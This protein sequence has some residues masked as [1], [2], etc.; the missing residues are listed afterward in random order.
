MHSM[1]GHGRGNARGANG[2]VTVEITSVN[3]RTLEI[4]VH[5]PDALA[6][7]EPFLHEQVRAAVQRGRVSIDVTPGGALAA[8][9][10][11]WDDAAV[12][13]AFERLREAA[14][15]LDVPFTPDAALLLRLAELH[16][17]TSASGNLE[18][19]LP[20]LESALAEALA[21]LQA[22]RAREGAALAEDFAARVGTL[23]QLL[24]AIEPELAALPGR[25]REALLQRLR[26]AGLE[27][28][29]ADERVV[30]EVAFFAER[31]DATEE[32][33]RLRSHF[34][35]MDAFLRST[36]PVGRR[37]EFL[38][39]EIQREFNTLGSKAG[40]P[41]VVRAVVE[42]KSELEKLREQAA[43]VE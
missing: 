15:R 22:M 27:L 31:C 10:L 38:L 37:I 6:A 35:Q 33:T 7:A 13:A 11:T 32:V 25:Q 12:A 3:R 30:K 4:V 19:V 5:L 34:A 42:A 40:S 20:L 18:A 28:D 41:A 39:Q 43:N 21:D 14:R 8:Q 1:T 24:L 26:Q 29:P 17:Q 16:R 2:E 23:R 9:G 36:E